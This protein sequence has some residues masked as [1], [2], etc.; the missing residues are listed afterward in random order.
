MKLSALHRFLSDNDSFLL[1][2]KITA[3]KKKQPSSSVRFILKQRLSVGLSNPKNLKGP[4]ISVP[5]A[6]PVFKESTDR[7]ILHT[8]QSSTNY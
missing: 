5:E 4:T 2:Y 6:L 8:L 3:H 7:L 1:A